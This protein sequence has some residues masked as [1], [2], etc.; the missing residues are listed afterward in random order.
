[1]KC[2]F[3]PSRRH[4]LRAGASGA[5]IAT[6]A[7]SSRMGLGIAMAQQ[8]NPL[9][10]QLLFFMRSMQY[11]GYFAAVERG[12]FK[13][14]W[15]RADFCHGRTQSIRSP[16]WQADSRS[17]ATGQSAPSLLRKTEAFPSR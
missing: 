11:G 7:S 14:V 4:L 9:S 13:E 1:M 12:S 2:R 3:D 5:A 10:F 8:A 6:F 15:D 16:T 17:S